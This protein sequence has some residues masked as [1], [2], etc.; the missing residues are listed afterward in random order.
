VDSRATRRRR[1][2]ST[3]T[4]PSAEDAVAPVVV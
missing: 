4:K 2:A 3:P 1:T